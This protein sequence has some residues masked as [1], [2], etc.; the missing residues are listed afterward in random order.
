MKKAIQLS[1]C[2]AFLAPALYAQDGVSTVDSL[3]DVHLN[4]YNID[5]DNTKTPGV[6]VERA[7]SELIKGK[8]AKKKIVVAVIDSGVDRDHEDL[9]GHIWVNSGEIAGN[10]I[11]LEA[12]MVKCW[13]L[14]AMN[15]PE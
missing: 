11:A 1:L 5:P 14:K 13:M 3:S 8:K 4:W 2:A 6:A 15:L 7:Y 9:D 10:G 12:R